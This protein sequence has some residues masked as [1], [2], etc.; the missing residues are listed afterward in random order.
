MTNK[1]PTMGHTDD[2]LT[3]RHIIGGPVTGW[4]WTIDA[5][6]HCKCPFCGADPGYHCQNPNGS[7]YLGT[8]SARAKMEKERQAS[9]RTF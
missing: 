8:H 4:W 5:D 2:N 9:L 1:F 6:R 3:E 7:R